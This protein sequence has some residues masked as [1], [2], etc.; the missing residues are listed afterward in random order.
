MHG[1]TAGDGGVHPCSR[2]GKQ[3]RLAPQKGGPPPEK[4]KGR[5]AIALINGWLRKSLESQEHS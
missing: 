1:P 5:L 3:R 2:R 4:N